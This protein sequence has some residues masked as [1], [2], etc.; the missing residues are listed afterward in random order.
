MKF[1]SSLSLLLTLGFAAKNVLADPTHQIV[2][3]F[4]NLIFF[5]N[6][7][8]S[9]PT[10]VQD[11]TDASTYALAAGAVIPINN[12]QELTFENVHANARDVFSSIGF[13]L[14]SSPTV[15]SP[16]P[17]VCVPSRTIGD[18]VGSIY[19]KLGGPDSQELGELL[20]GNNADVLDPEAVNVIDSWLANGVCFGG[21]DAPNRVCFE[22]EEYVLSVTY[23]GE[24]DTRGLFVENYRV[25]ITPVPRAELLFAQ[26]DPENQQE[27]VFRVTR[28][29]ETSWTFSQSV[30]DFVRDE[31]SEKLANSTLASDNL[32]GPAFVLDRDEVPVEPFAAARILE[33]NANGVCPGEPETENDTNESASSAA[34]TG[35]SALALLS[36]VGALFF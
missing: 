35:A 34:R 25:F 12:G 3:A 15:V 23:L 32:V 8:I 33:P 10:F 5:D 4:N 1:L 27:E 6:E 17:G 24:N 11:F 28:V 20:Q 22:E 13:R 30:Y 36:V 26:P 16:D 2:A 14:D 21:A 29:V 31:I 9:N 19:T 18:I 7:Q